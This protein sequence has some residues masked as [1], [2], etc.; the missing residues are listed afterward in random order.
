MSVVDKTGNLRWNSTIVHKAGQSST[1][2]EAEWKV[3]RESFA[4][5]PGMDKEYNVQTT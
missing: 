3:P 2:V 5:P 1:L 4:E